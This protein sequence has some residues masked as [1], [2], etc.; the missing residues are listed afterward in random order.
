MKKIIF[1]LLITLLS[2]CFSED[3]TIKKGNIENKENKENTINKNI[4]KKDNTINVAITDKKTIEVTKIEFKKIVDSY[5][6]KNNIDTSKNFIGWLKFSKKWIEYMLEDCSFIWRKW[7][8]WKEK[9]IEFLLEWD[10]DLYSYIKDNN[11]SDVS[12]TNKIKS[13]FKYEDDYDIFYWILYSLWKISE[14]EFLELE[15]TFFLKLG[16]TN[17]SDYKISE[18][19]ITS[20]FVRDTFLGKNKGDYCKNIV[21]TFWTK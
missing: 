1:V 11:I 7:I 3:N 21:L 18:S 15:E 10:M 9:F 2:S 8:N 16:L 17:K 14:K 20:I 19:V 12:L 5:S 13:F 4:E 6:I